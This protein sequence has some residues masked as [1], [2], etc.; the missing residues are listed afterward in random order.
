MTLTALSLGTYLA[1][2]GAV[3][4]AVFVA[5]LLRVRHRRVPVET[6]LFFR[7]TETPSRPRVLFG[8]PAR[9]LSMLAAMLA[10]A[11]IWTAVADPVAAGD[12]ASRFVVVAGSSAVDPELRD[13]VL[14]SPLGPR[15]RIVTADD[16]G[17]LLAGADEPRGVAT[18]RLD[19]REAA[20]GTAVDGAAELVTALARPGDAVAAHGVDAPSVRPGVHVETS[21]WTLVRGSRDDVADSRPVRPRRVRIDPAVPSVVATAVASDRRFIVASDG[22]AEALVV[23]AETARSDPRSPM[24]VIEPGAN[25]RERRA[26]ATSVLPLPLGTFDRTS[27]S[28][29][30]LDAQPGETTW[31]EDAFTTEPLVAARPRRGDGGPQ[32]RVVEWLLAPAAHRD[33][34][35]LVCGALAMLTGVDRPARVTAGQILALPALATNPILVRGSET[36]TVLPLGGSYRFSL[37]RPGSAVLDDGVTSATVEVEAAAVTQRPAASSST[38]HERG[39]VRDP[40]RLRTWLIAAALLALV[41]DIWLYRRGSVP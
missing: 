28:G 15:G 35:I 38:S 13:E 14:S 8:M 40:V 21:R 25:A 23:M 11:A 10:A 36:F 19:P 16:D 30:R 32:V 26:V 41:L 34:P 39:V 20:P 31:V 29:T 17:G 7:L 2:I 5:H 18:A 24:L 6:L 27:T 33:V 4:A 12:D 22:E 9:W 3:A 37:H 1:G